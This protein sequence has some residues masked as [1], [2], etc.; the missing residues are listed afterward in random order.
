M[1]T[2]I[3]YHH[4]YKY[5]VGSKGLS[6]QTK[7]Y[8]Y[9]IRLPYLALT[10]NGTLTVYRGYKFDGPSGVAKDTDNF[11]DGS[12]FHDAGHQFMRMGLLPVKYRKT[13]D[14]LMREI[15]RKSRPRMNWFRKW[16]TYRGVRLFG[17]QSARA[18][19]QG[20]VPE[21]RSILANE[22]VAVEPP[23]E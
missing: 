10:P 22:L 21:T 2:Y 19:S 12:C 20:M 14:K 6:V 5:E 13:F 17:A 7:I 8:G 15:N 18:G 11:M 3:V 23:G 4:S 16:Y 1:S 9:D